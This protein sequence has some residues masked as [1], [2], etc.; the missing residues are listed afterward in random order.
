[1]DSIEKRVAI[2]TLGCR[3]NQYDSTAMEDFVTDAGFEVAPFSADAGV[4]IINT[5]TVTH[6]T[7]GEGRQLVR[8]VRRKHPD[9]VI[10]VT[11]C[12]A[13][14]SPQEVA[15]IEGVDY[16]LGNPEK[17]RVVECIKK[18]RQKD[19]ALVE[20]G[21]YQKGTPLKLRAQNHLQPKAGRNVRTRVNLKVQDGCNKNCAFCVIPL[22]R[23]RSKSVALADV[24]AEIKGLV[25]KGFKEMV[26]TGIHLGAYG[27][28]FEKGYSILKLLREIEA[29]GFD[30]KFRV[31]SLDPDEVGVEMIEFLA[32]A[33]SI[34]NHL[35]L[36]VQSGDDKVLKMMNRPYSARSFAGTVRALA[37][38]VCDISVGTDVIV[39]F[40]GEGEQ[41]FENTYNLLE[42]LPLSYMHIFPYS[43]RARTLAID[44]PG[45]NDP[46][47]IKA[48]SVRLHALDARKRQ[49]FYERF[50]GRE[51]TV[52]IE[53]ARDRKTGLL[54]GRTTNYI[55]VLV[56]GGDELKSNDITVTLTDI[57]KDGMR[58]EL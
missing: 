24:M 19:G 53:S 10:I 36:P 32:N 14:V 55:P 2:T 35:H 34:C 52:L 49:G 3:S 41:E 17:D 48:R 57:M 56:E 28:D 16:V 15:E 22:A 54:K 12:Y 31:S 6:K 1:M 45:H 43:K 58:G 20:V 25:E 33:G 39:G 42:A 7:D 51:M 18:G 47:V 8:K 9:S 13:Q 40:P 5:C 11:G 50:V 27:M 29:V 21:D 37:K 4:Y 26:L 30:A 46:K 44:M 38:E 23:G